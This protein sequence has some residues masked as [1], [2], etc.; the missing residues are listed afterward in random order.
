M[1]QA[2]EEVKEAW[3]RPVAEDQSKDYLVDNIIAILCCLSP[4]G[5]IGL[6]KALLVRQAKDNRDFE[7]ARTARI[8]AR[9]MRSLGWLYG[10]IVS[11]ILV[12]VFWALIENYPGH[13]GF[14]QNIQTLNEQ[15]G[16]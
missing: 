16:T 14:V 15:Q 6:R 7:A 13:F 5:F 2:F 3:D 4:C 1:K 11:A 10:L 8:Q 12:V 9:R